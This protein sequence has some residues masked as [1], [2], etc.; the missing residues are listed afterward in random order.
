[1]F[2]FKDQKFI[3]KET[4]PF[5]CSKIISFAVWINNKKII[6]TNFKTNFKFFMNQQAIFGLNNIHAH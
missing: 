6:R 4:L 1:M 3:K 5:R 2:N